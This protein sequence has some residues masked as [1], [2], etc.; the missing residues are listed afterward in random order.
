MHHLE[1]DHWSRGDGYLHRRDA[2]AKLL[3][4]LSLLLIVA[5]TPTAYAPWLWLYG[6]VP[7]TGLC[8]SR[9][10]LA[11][12]LAFAAA[13]LPFAL[14]VALVQWPVA[15]WAKTLALVEKSYVSALAALALVATTPLPKLAQGLIS[16][17]APRFLVLV[18]QFVYR[19]LFVV[20]EQ[21]QHVRLAAASR[22]ADRTVRFSGDR[23][24]T[25]AGALGA[26]FARSY[27]RAEGTYQAMLAR[28]FS[29]R[30]HTVELSHLT[31]KD[32]GFLVLIVIGSLSIYKVIVLVNQWSL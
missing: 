15:G 29:G 32:L 5:L 22:G 4:L 6:F 8:A 24:R 28:G 26:L 23:L 18:T 27:Q 31:R 19:Y 9:I 3:G 20:S 16:L 10:P 14:P 13:V 25:A 11:R 12:A 1:L 2:R 30:I 17:G 21:S 7:L